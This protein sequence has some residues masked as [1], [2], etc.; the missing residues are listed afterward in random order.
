MA[1][2]AV[3]HIIGNIGRDPETRFTPNNQQVTSFTVAV[4]RV[5]TQGSE[6]K[7]ET[8]WYRVSAWGKLAQ[9]AEQYLQK[10]RRV[11]VSGRFAPRTF[12]GQDGQTRISL[13]ISADYI[14]P[15]DSQ[16]RADVNELPPVGASVPSRGRPS[17]IDAGDPD[18]TD[19]D[20]PF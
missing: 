6:R 7:E 16:P 8:D 3:I 13:D 17:P 19:D 9:F 1:S 5:S 20:I 12:I 18:L 4:N 14:V 2:M 11:Y 10:G 15:A